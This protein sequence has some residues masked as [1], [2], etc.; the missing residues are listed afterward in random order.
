MITP[1]SFDKTNLP[2]F[3]DLL[4]KLKTQDDALHRYVVPADVLQF[5]DGKL[6]APGHS[7]DVPTHYFAVLCRAVNAPH[8]YLRRL[9]EPYTSYLLA[10]HFKR[11]EHLKSLE[12][13]KVL[14]KHHRH[15]GNVTLLARGHDFVGF[16]RPDLQTLSGADVLDQVH[17]A[18]RAHLKDS[19][20]NLIVRHF[21]MDPTSFE[22]TVSTPAIKHEVKLGDIIEGGLQVVHSHAS[23]QS[24]RIESYIHRLAC[25]NGAIRRECLNTRKGGTARIRRR[26]ANRLDSVSA[27]LKAIHKHTSRALMGLSRKLEAVSDLRETKLDR[28]QGVAQFI[29]AQ[30]RQSPRLFSRRLVQGVINAWQQESEESTAYGAWNALTATATH[31]PDSQLRPTV[32]RA[33]LH[34]SGV[35]A[36]RSEHVCPKCYQMVAN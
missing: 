20:D 4:I 6:I 7:L 31:A 26:E 13:Q 32:R 11:G 23:S 5:R 36:T 9:G 33:L 27:S 35:I 15:A 14:G 21:H 3:G 12:Q 25:S 10:H 1:S 34:L 22:L 28:K 19:C 16:A 24:T 8:A 18:T 30:L 29:E 17:Q 2:T